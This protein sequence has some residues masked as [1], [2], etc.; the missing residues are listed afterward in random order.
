MNAFL[1]DLR[2]GLRILINNPGYAL[3]GVIAL[4]LGI[5]A[6]AGAFT[7][8]SALILHPLPFKDLDRLVMMWETSARLRLE[9]DPVAP[10]NFIDWR[11]QSTAFEQMA[12]YRSW[13]VN[14]T[15]V[16]QPERLQGCLVSASFFPLLGVS[17][18]L[19]RVFSPEEEQV[20][21]DQVVVVSHGFWQRS[22]GANPNIVGAWVILDGRAF[23]VVG[24]MSPEFDFPLG[25][26]LW[27]PLAFTTEERGQRGV[28]LLSVLARLQPGVSL[29]QARAEMAA[30]ASRLE[31]QY[32][33]TNAERGVRVVPLLEAV[34]SALTIRFMLIIGAAGG[35]VLLLACANVANLQLARVTG[36]HK[37]IA[38]RAALGASRWQLVRQLIAESVLVS[39]LGAVLAVLMAVWGV[40]LTRAA[41]PQEIYRARP[42]LKYLAVDSGVLGF[43]LILALL[44]GM[45]S[46]LVPALHASGRKTLFALNDALKEGGRTSGA[47]RAGGRARGLLVVT[48]MALALVLLVGA[49]LMVKT[50]RHMSTVDAGFNPRNLLTM[51]LALPVARYHQAHQAAAFYRQV[52]ERLAALPEVQAAATAGNLGTAEGFLIE[53]RPEPQP[54]E[55]RPD[56]QPVS[57]NYFRAMG[58]PILRGRPVSEQDAAEAP[59]AAVLSESLVRHYWPRAGN[60]VGARVKVGGP[61]S[62]WLSVVGVVG[63]VKDWF[64]GEP[65]P[66]IYLS[67]LQRPQHSMKLLIRTSGDP[68]RLASGAR[69]QVRS[70]DPDQPVYDVE[71][72]E[73]YLAG[74][75]SGIRIS[76]TMIAVFAAMALVLAAAGIYGVI[77]YSA[78]QRTHEMGVRMALGAT[79]GDV[80]MAVVGPALKLALAGLAVGL[81]AAYAMSRAMSSTLFGVIA[82]DVGTFAAFTLLLAAVALAACYIP[83]RRA[84]R[85]DPAVA[86]RYE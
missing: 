78:A 74:Q 56:V 83:A 75:T 17:P 4:G 13:D 45:I 58:I 60:P 66:A 38:I 16:D 50:F 84:T 32:P 8:I 30:V 15:G 33:S 71:S 63:D 28:H 59:L 24:V 44:A 57:A 36:R 73:Q 20:G 22:L 85:V 39:L 10:A 82:L 40:D 23:T 29:P 64:S 80:L 42:G 65:E 12:A 27:G 79:R 18:S 47:G 51:R 68:L 26:D 5:G 76:A 11:D 72:M 2:Y 69:A 46:G 77:S 61:Q 6:N 9:R 54:S 41:I 3:V 19:G 81:P 35:F 53:G 1:Q 37:E 67:H 43:T 25:T 31:R 55:P 70:L 14:L 48:E 7:G 21:H 49:G 52:R 34:V 86:L 62:P